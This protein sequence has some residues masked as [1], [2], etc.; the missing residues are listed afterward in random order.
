MTK[1]GRRS[2]EEWKRLV[3]EWQRSG[4]SAAEFCRARGLSERTLAWWR[5]RLR[6]AATPAVPPASRGAVRLVPVEV[7]PVADDEEDYEDGSEPAW[8][9]ETPEGVVLRVYDDGLADVLR[10]AV[11]AVLR[12]DGVR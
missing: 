8:E 6:T 2:S 3:G 7:E 10:A 1:Q 12:G 9:L 4:R 5:W 11:A